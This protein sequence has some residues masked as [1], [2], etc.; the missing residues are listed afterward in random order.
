MEKQFSTNNISIKLINQIG[1]V[2]IPYQTGQKQGKKSPIIKYQRKANYNCDKITELSVI[3]HTN[4][5]QRILN[6][7]RLQA[8]ELIAEKQAGFCSKRSITE[9]TFMFYMR[10]T[11]NTSKISTKSSS[12]FSV[13]CEQS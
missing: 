3:S 4:D 5:A 7:L 9:H 12:T 1:E 10:N 6:R 11:A 2:V 8:K 13:V